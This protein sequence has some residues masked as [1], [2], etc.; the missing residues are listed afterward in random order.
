[1]AF[2]DPVAP[3]RLASLGAGGVQWRGAE[4][5]PLP[6]SREEASDVGELFGERARI[7]LGADVSEQTIFA[8]APR[9]R[10]IHFATHAVLDPRS[11]FDSYLVI[12]GS[13]ATGEPYGRLRAAEIFDRLDL[14]ADLVALSA[15][16]TAGSD[17]SGGEGLMGLTRA[18]HFAGAKRVLSSLWPVS[19]RSTSALMVA[20]YR[21]LRRGR[22]A[23]EALRAA[24]MEMIA[25]DGGTNRGLFDWL[26]SSDAREP[27]HALP[28]H[29]AAF[30][31][32]TVGSVRRLPAQSKSRSR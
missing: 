15:C 3:E 12:A 25:A 8:E 11:P 18:F 22:D 10:R 19:D 13:A 20:F 24:Q 21:E 17:E 30:E 4:F 28:F 31:L 32:S 1:V 7:H 29:W 5:G 16:S 27:S 14:R 6:W 23:D 9:A 26:H 2:A